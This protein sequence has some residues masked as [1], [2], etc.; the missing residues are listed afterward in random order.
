VRDVQGNEVIVGELLVVFVI[1]NI[2]IILSPSPHSRPD[3]N[4]Y[5]LIIVKNRF[6]TIHLFGIMCVVRHTGEVH[7]GN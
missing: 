1:G 2:G 5:P 3:R 7:I 4:P 6:I